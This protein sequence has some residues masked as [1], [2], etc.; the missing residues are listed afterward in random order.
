MKTITDNIKAIL[1]ILVV[2]LGFAYFFM[3][4]IRNLKPDP[5]ILIAMVTSVSAVLGYH[6]GSSSSKADNKPT[7]Q[8]AETVN[9]QTP[10]TQTPQGPAQG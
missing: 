10:T 9:V 6:F 8:N 3:C 5:Q 7:V 2:A 4:S 1:S